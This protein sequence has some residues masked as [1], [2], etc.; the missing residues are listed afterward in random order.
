M[1]ALCK[2]HAIDMTF[3]LPQVGI[4]LNKRFSQCGS[5]HW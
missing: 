1:D 3:W 4:L 2:C 5:N